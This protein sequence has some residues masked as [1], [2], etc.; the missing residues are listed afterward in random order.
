[1][2]EATPQLNIY[3]IQKHEHM[4]LRAFQPLAKTYIIF[5]QVISFTSTIAI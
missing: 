2:I 3:L 1:M 5:Y 4:T